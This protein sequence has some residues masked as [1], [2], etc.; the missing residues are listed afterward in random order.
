VEAAFECLSELRHGLD[1]AAGGEA[2]ATLDRM[3]D[4]LITK[5]TMG[6]A[7]KDAQQFDQVV[8]SVLTI[9]E[10]WQELFDRLRAE[11]KLTTED[12]AVSR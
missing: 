8:Q 3:Y 11:G 9:R 7:S 12:A 4:F 10:A 5:L 2:A 6:N 1:L